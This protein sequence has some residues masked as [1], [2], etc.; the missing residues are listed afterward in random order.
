MAKEHDKRDLKVSKIFHS[1]TLEKSLWTNPD[2]FLGKLLITV[3]SGYQPQSASDVLDWFTEWSR[4]LHHGPLA[5]PRPEGHQPRRDGG[6]LEDDQHP[7][8]QG[9]VTSQQSQNILRIFLSIK[10]NQ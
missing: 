10:L 5:P 4:L 7:R 6:T 9:V 3:M 2:L 1:K 8:T